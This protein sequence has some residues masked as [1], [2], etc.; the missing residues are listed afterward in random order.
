MMHNFMRDK[1]LLVILYI[2]RIISPRLTKENLN[3]DPTSE[4]SYELA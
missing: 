3:F 4:S 1:Q 2:S